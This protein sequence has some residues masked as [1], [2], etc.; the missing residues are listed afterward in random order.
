MV[1]VISEGVPEGNARVNSKLAAARSKTPSEVDV[2][3]PM[4]GCFQ[5]QDTTYLAFGYGIFGRRVESSHG[6]GAA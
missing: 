1:T 3:S 5:Q 6:R 2:P 4:A